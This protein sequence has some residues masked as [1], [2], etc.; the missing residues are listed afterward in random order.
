[1]IYY[2]KIRW[3]NFL[4]YGNNWTEID[5]QQNKKTI[6]LGESG[7][8]KSTFLDALKFVCFNKPY[9]SITKPQL[10][11]SINNKEC[12]V[13]VEFKRGDKDFKIVRGMKP[14]IFE[15]HCD[16]LLVNQDASSRD[17]Q[18]WLEKNVFGFNAKSFDQIVVVGAANFTPFMQLKPQDRRTIIEE[19]L[20]LQIFGVMNNL[21]KEKISLNKEENTSL[22]NKIHLLKEK[23]RIHKSFIQELEKDKKEKITL[24][25][26]KLQEKDK[27]LEDVNYKIGECCDLINRLKNNIQDETKINNELMNLNNQQSHLNKDIDNL[28]KEIEFF[29]SHEN[30]NVCKQN[31]DENFKDEKIREI[32]E[33]IYFNNVDLKELKNKYEEI[34]TKK[35]KIELTKFDIV[36]QETHLAVLKTT[37][38]N[39]ENVK[40]DLESEI[41]KFQ[42]PTE[43]IVEEKKKLKKLFEE[44]KLSEKNKEEV[45]NEKI[46][47]EYAQSLLKDTGVKSQIIKQYLPLINQHTNKFLSMMNFFATFYID[48]NFNEYI[49]SR[50]FDDFTYSSFSEGEKQRIDLALLFTWRVIAKMKNSVGTNLLVMDE[51]FDS[52]LDIEAT[53]NCIE[54]LNSDLFRNINVFVISHKNDIADKFDD[55]IEF[56]KIKNFS[57]IK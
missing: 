33:K 27:E 34:L 49:K 45:V 31:I 32:K 35:G 12:V 46:I 56:N 24:L 9:R 47:Y 14:N 40:R 28:E 15:I 18:L 36:K 7:S 5:L 10:I 50:G 21:L 17:Y 55:V 11:N 38:T 13:E 37:K 54:I 4:S 19:L 25:N 6:L 23:M 22:E 41:K 26:D 52:Y 16:G 51:I 57:E 43:S 39:I 8:G 3:K 30:C 1:M 53:E 20:D 48:E 42:S 2:Q 29:E 44:F